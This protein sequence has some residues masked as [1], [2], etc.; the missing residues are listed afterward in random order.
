MSSS[1]IG[2]PFQD[3]DTPCLVLDL[4]AAQRN[5][6]RMADF[7]ADKPAKLRPHFKNHK[8]TELMKR[9]VVREAAGV[10][11]AKLGEAEVL[12]GAGFKDILI[13]NQV[14]GPHKIKR[15]LALLSRAMVRVAVDAEDNCRL[16][17]QM[18]A[19]AGAIVGCLIEVNIGMDR[20]GVEP[21]EPAVELAKLIAGLP[22]LR[23]DGIQAYEGHVVTLPDPEERRA[24]VTRDM[25]KA[26]DTADLI[27]TRLGMPVGIVSGGGTGTYDMTGALEGVDEIQA[28]TYVTMDCYYHGVRPEFENALSVLTTCVS[29]PSATRAVLDVGV[30]GV[31]AEFGVP[32]VRGREGVEIPSFRS[33]EHC[34]LKVTGRPL[35]VGEKVELIPSH[36]CTTC[37]LHR[38]LYVCQQGRVV[39]VWPIDGSGKLR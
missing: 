15:L 18:A 39:D 32:Q 36:A 8:C 12:V 37:N 22:G 17:S 1:M 33:E 38:E 13:A 30:K 6:D 5:I 23:F 14:V 10:T 24:A 2:G 3:L 31:G 28:G 19:A 9:Q 26:L 7:F 16:L 4:D 21:G 29:S 25:H 20:C 11:C 35:V 27:E 34:I